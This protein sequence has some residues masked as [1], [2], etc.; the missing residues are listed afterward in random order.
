MYNHFDRAHVK[1]MGVKQMACNH[2]KCK[3]DA[4]KFEHLNHFKK[5][6]TASKGLNVFTLD[7]NFHPRPNTICPD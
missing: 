1:H 6:S 7:F 4:L 5:G 2:P 3:G